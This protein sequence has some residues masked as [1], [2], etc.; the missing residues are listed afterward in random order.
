MSV[1]RASGSRLV[2]HVGLGMCLALV[3]LTP[4]HEG[5]AAAK[6]FVAR[7]GV[8]CS[9]ATGTVRFS[10]ALRSA[11][12][13]PE[14]TVFHVRFSHCTTTASSIHSVAAATVSA[15]VHRSNNSCAEAFMSQPSSGT[16]S[17][18]PSRIRPSRFTFSGYSIARDAAGHDGLGL[19]GAGGRAVVS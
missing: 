13:V 15:K 8:S 11:G 1:M 3:M 4:A 6:T 2:R 5:S 10:P 12:T 19:P 9:R 17:W 18:S 16:V 14:T 7:G